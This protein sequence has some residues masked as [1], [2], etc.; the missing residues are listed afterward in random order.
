MESLNSQYDFDS[1]IFS[2]EG[3]L[4]QVEYAREAIKKGSTTIALKYKEGVIILAYKDI[5]SNLIEVSSIDKINLI[6]KNYL[7]AY[8]G[9]SADAR[10]LIEYSQEIAANYKI[11]Y[12]EQIDLKS[13]VKELCS[14]MHLFTTFGGVRPFG[15]VLFIAG[16]DSSGI[17]IFATDPSG[18]FLEYKAI[19]EGIKN[20]EIIKYLN[21][22]YNDN[23]SLEKSIELSVNCIK[24]VF[25]RK[26]NIDCV[27]VGIIDKNKGFYKLEKSKIKKMIK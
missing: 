21:K 19:C 4:F 27:E 15:L 18:S 16:I 6:D 13:L 26:I 8:I 12:D 5:S 7:C 14:Y 20:K 3:R 9:L 2:P 10:H 1:T 23:L 11:W 17:H 25:K 24:K 22:Q